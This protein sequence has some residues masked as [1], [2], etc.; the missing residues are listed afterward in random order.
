MG[1]RMQRRVLL[2]LGVTATAACV[3]PT[4]PL[5]PPDAP[6]SIGLSTEAGMWDIRGS[7][8]PG[9]VVLIKNL[10]TGRIYGSEDR[11][12]DGRYFVQVQAEECDAAEVW[13][14]IGDHISDSSFFV[15]EPI[16]N[17]SP[18]A[19]NCSDS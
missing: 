19:N 18:L 13:E 2:G 5:P 8:T 16:A 10:S 15:I 3:S 12:S 4:L 11:D 9:A 17:S 7:S 1:V 14:L 6:D